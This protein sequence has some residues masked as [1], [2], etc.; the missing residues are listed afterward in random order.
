MK[1]NELIIVLILF[2]GS[3]GNTIYCQSGG[4]LFI[5]EGGFMS[6]FGQHNFTKGGG[7]IAPGKVTTS[8]KGEKGYL[9]FTKGSDWKGA[10]AS[11]FVDG[12]VC[13]FHS[14]QFL[15]PIGNLNRYRPIASS[16]ARKTTA[17]YYYKSPAEVVRTNNTGNAEEATNISRI[18]NREYWDVG[19]TSPVEL[20]FLWGE[21]SNIANITG[22]KLENLILVG[23]KNGEWEVIP[24]SIEERVPDVF[25]QKHPELIQP[26]SFD[27]GV[28]TTD[29]AI[30]PNDYE[31]ITIGA[32]EDAEEADGRTRVVESDIIA[33]YPNPVENDMYLDLKEIKNRTGVIRIY[34]IY[35]I[36]VYERIID[37]EFDQLQHFDTSNLDNGMYDIYVKLGEKTL[38]RKFVVGRLY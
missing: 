25:K 34:N 29:K 26:S 10:S 35:G 28:I 6:V 36:Q 18:S 27:L 37:R 8:R 14:N 21:D 22:G 11:K 15:F 13:V 4:K 24:A 32:K 2:L 1:K 17:A 12:Y 7:L 30:V 38:S 9:N 23:W 20:S 3:L 5:Q 33:V 31:L 19:G 16:G